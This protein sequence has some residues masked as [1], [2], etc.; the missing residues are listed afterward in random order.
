MESID[1]LVYKGNLLIYYAGFFINN[2]ENQQIF[3]DY[4]DNLTKK[5]IKIGIQQRDINRTKYTIL[6]KLNEDLGILY[7]AIKKLN[8]PDNLESDE[9]IKDINVKTEYYELTL[10]VGIILIEY[11][12][13]EDPNTIL[14]Y[15]IKLIELY[16]SY[17]NNKILKLFKIINDFYKNIE[18]KG[19]AYLYR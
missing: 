12:K 7:H 11:I 2:K 14:E 10:Q 19:I 13:N 6:N 9:E 4:I 18:K 3:L 15:I 17:N 5:I 1:E 8:I 16:N